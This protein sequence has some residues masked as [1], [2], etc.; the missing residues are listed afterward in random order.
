MWKFKLGDEPMKPTRLILTGLIAALVVSLCP[1]G[2]T[3]AS[4]Q[5]GITASAVAVPAQISRL[6]FTVSALVRDVPV[7]EGEV[8]QAGQTLMILDTPELEYAVIAAEQDYKAKALEAQLQKAERVKYVNPNNG[9]IFW[10]SIP[11]EVYLKALSKADQSKAAWDIAAASLAQTTLVAPFD[12]TV[13]DIQVFP[14]ETVQANQVVLVLADVQ[15]MQITT[16]DLSERDI[17]KIGIG[18]PA[19]VY[20]EALNETIQGEVIGIAPKAD[21]IGGDVVFKVTIA[22]NIQPPALLWGMTAEVSIGK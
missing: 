17:A 20:I 5:G 3:H 7:R 14:G 22:L 6:G 4:A 12:G 16:T 18:D 19:Q 11:R 1:A 2:R 10:F 21:V 15:H 8:V 9:K 13:A